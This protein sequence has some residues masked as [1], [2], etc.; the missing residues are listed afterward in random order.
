MPY[1][2][3]DYRAESTTMARDLKKKKKKKFKFI[4]GFETVQVKKIMPLII[5]LLKEI[6]LRD[7]RKADVV[8]ACST[9]QLI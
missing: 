5:M 3:R 8:I 6:E 2:I 7:N 1:P 9:I 4:S